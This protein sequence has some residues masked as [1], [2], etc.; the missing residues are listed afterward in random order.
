VIRGPGASPQPGATADS[1]GRPA[2]VVFF[3]AGPFG[4][5]ILDALVTLPGVRLVGVVSVPDRPAGRGGRVTAPPIAERARQ[6]ALDPMQP[7]RLRDPAVV[8]A[9]HALEP[10]VA[11]LAD[12]GRLVPPEILVV[13]ARGFLNLHPSLLPRHRG[14]TPIQAAILAGDAQTGVTLFEMDAG[15]DTGSIV[16]QEAWPLAGSEAASELEAAA[17]TRAASLLRAMLPRWL[18]G[19]VAARPQP[20]AGMTL[21]R[22]LAREDGRLDPHEPAAALARRVRAFQPW[23]GAFLETSAGRLAVLR[24][25]ARPPV[26]GDEP[27]RVVGAD[28]GLAMTTADGRLALLE[29]RP[30]GGRSMSAGDLARGRPGY[31]DS[32]VLGRGDED[33]R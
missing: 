8:A 7:A 16:A 14:A 29:V 5:P 30:A 25:E 17:A 19:S 28:G 4:L 24:A 32:R 31:V 15:L 10:D 13:P 33:R 1:S 11:V 2:R 6:L 27:G 21:T 22:P 3:G 12:Y 23:P 26:A 20:D 18:E 9:L